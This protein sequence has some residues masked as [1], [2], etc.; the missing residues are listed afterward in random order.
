MTTAA[1]ASPAAPPARHAR[2][3]KGVER[4]YVNELEKLVS[5]LAVRLLVLVCAIGPFAFALVLKVQS[6]TP[7]DALFGVWVHSS[8]FAISLVVLGFAGSWGFPV[9][10][11]VL[12]GDMF[13]SEDRHGTWKT[14]LTRSCSRRDVFAGKVLAA[15]TFATVLLAITAVSSLLAGA[16]LVGAHSLVDLSGIL[17]SPAVRCFSSPSAGSSAC[18]RC[19]PTRAWPYC[20]RWQHVTASSA[21]SGRSWLHWS[22]NCSTSSARAWVHLLLIGSAFNGFYGLRQWLTSRPAR[23]AVV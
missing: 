13:S 19:W 22:H 3:T 11:G 6:G 15:A 2:S 16:L 18:S 12:A 21:S 17:L 7:S 20:S 4:V 14:I 5:Q 10:A 9:M 8:G 1:A 23:S